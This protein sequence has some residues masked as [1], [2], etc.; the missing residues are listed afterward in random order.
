MFDRF[1]F[2]ILVF[3]NYAFSQ[4]NFNVSIKLNQCDSLYFCEASNFSSNSVTI[5][6]DTTFFIESSS[7]LFYVQ[8]NNEKYYL[9]IDKDS[10]VEL[11]CNN[12]EFLINGPN[13][14]FIIF[15]NEYY[16]LYKP[17]IDSLFLKGYVSDQFE[18]ELYNLLSNEIAYFY[19]NHKFFDTFQDH[20][21][22]YFKDLLK[23]EYF[24]SI[25]SYLINQKKDTSQIFPFYN[26]LNID[27]LDRLV[28]QEHLVDT[29]YY[30]LDVFQNY[31]S[32]SFILFSIDDFKYMTE[33]NN[34]F[35]NFNTY[36]FDVIEDKMPSDLLLS[37]LNYYA[38]NYAQF[39]DDRIIFYIKSLLKKYSFDELIV[40]R[41]LDYYSNNQKKTNLLQEEV[42]SVLDFYME[43]EEGD[44]V[45][46]DS[47][48]G[49]LL[50][51]DLWAS[52]CGPCRK[53]FPY[54]QKLKKKFSKRQLKKIKFI[55][56]SIDNDHEKWK[57]SLDKLDLNGHQ[58]ISPA[59]NN[60][61]A[62]NY[63]QISSIPRYIIIDENGVI[64]NENAKRPSDETL[65]QD[66]L[67]LIK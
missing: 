22:D 8:N 59:N 32:N 14:N 19:N 61:G 24:N 39:L 36:I 4:A 58:F 6:S 17:K 25:S 33:K 37:F 60:N 23:Y 56:I 31:I 66:L 42:S 27:L 64:L 5:Y 50:Y 28:L 54:A 46:L 3:F 15:L 43:N 49:K 29:N 53:Q 48:Q 40:S 16:S 35:Y 18:I 1:L 21:H 30:G 13:S 9:F 38:S 62:G 51:I 11:N 12:H 44:I 2:F 41:M 55:Y 10:I 67:D 7:K 47:F 65:F 57:E 26:E 45:S 20:C 52:W 34:N 63:F